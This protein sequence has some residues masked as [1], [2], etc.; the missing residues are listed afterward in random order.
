LPERDP[1]C[2]CKY[3][4]VRDRM[5]R[6]DWPFHCDV[7][8]DLAADEVRAEPLC[9]GELEAGMKIQCDREVDVLGILLSESP[10]EEGG[11]DSAAYVSQGYP[12]RFAKSRTPVKPNR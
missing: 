9:F 12:H 7:P 4:Q 3:D 5:D 2:E 10:V 11:E 1:F 8:D 6:E